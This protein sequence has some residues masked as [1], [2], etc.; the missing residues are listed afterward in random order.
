MHEIEVDF[1]LFGRVLGGTG[2]VSYRDSQSISIP[3]S[4]A[5][6]NIERSD[7]RN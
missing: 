6:M 7:S 5:L 4:T 3:S 1:H 2:V